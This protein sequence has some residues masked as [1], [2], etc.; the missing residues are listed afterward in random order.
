MYPNIRVSDHS[1]DDTSDD[2][3]DKIT[4][5]E[6]PILD[7]QVNSNQGR[8][9]KLNRVMQAR[10]VQNNLT[11]DQIEILGKKNA[12]SLYEIQASEDM[13]ENLQAQFNLIQ[14]QK[15]ETELMSRNIEEAKL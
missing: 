6:N 13:K 4:V 8:L 5:I 9:A 3:D 14:Q 15:E 2:H 7:K 1:Q 10:T 12:H 11:K